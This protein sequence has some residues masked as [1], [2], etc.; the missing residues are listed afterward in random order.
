MLSLKQPPSLSSAVL[1]P[2][3][4]PPC[5]V[6]GHIGRWM[7]ANVTIASDHPKHHDFDWMIVVF[8]F[9]HYRLHLVGEK[10]ANVCSLDSQTDPGRSFSPEKKQYMF[11]WKG[12]LR[13]FKNFLTRSSIFQGQRKKNWSFHVLYEKYEMYSCIICLIR[14]SDT[15]MSLAMNLIDLLGSFSI[16]V[17]IST[18]NLTVLFLSER[19]E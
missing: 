19:S 3:C 12:C 5:R 8:F 10:Q 2:L 14:N 4:R 7:K 13:F 17:W 11:G 6:W 9:F 18:A 1:C 15:S 16:I